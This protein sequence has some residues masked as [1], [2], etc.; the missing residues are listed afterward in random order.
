MVGQSSA[1]G[2][3]GGWGLQPCHPSH[4]LRISPS[5]DHTDYYY[6]CSTDSS[7]APTTSIHTLRVRGLGRETS[8]DQLQAA[9]KPVGFTASRGSRL[10]PFTSSAASTPDPPTCSLAQQSTFMTST[11]SFA[12]AEVKTKAA[13]KLRVDHPSWEV[14]DQFAGLTILSA[15]DRIDME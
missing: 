11:V 5:S 12:S 14:D 8:I 6:N 13:K 9:M 15:P 1:T 7:M 2:S 3:G 10:N 4:F